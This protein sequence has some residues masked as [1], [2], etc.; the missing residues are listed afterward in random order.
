MVS[1]KL[2]W[3]S[4]ISTRG[5]RFAGADIKNMYLETPLDRYEYMKMSLSLFP[6]DI[7]NHYGLL[8]KALN[9][10]IYMEIHKGMYGLPQ[11]GIMA[12]KFLR[13][14]LAKHGYFKQPHT[15]GL[16][17]HKSHPVWF[18][19]A[20]DDFVIKY[21]GEE[22]LQH[23]YNALQIEMYD[24]V[25]DQTGNLYCGINLKWNYDK[26]YVDLAMLQYL[27]KQLTHYAHPA[28]NKPQHCPFSPNPI[29][30]RKDNQAPTPAN[31]SPLLNDAGKKCIQHVIGSFLYYARDVNPTTLMALPHIATQQLAPTE[32]KKKQVDQ[33][34]DYMW[35]HPD[36]TI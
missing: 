36:A 31:K 23:L 14:R 26:G 33:F 13:K 8:D 29:T 34:L 18:N 10:Y 21:I 5:A 32:N 17:K 11:A 25:E 1:S 20:V 16:W 12:N 9:G 35:T 2:L 22:H 24:I 27:M 30:Y 7:I 28:P 4:T 19:L 3:N 15:P 6:Q